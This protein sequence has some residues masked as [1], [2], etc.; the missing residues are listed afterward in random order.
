MKKPVYKLALPNSSETQVWRQILY[1]EVYA[2]MVVDTHGDY[3]S[4]ETIETMAHNFLK[5][6]YQ[7]NI[8]VMHDGNHVTACIVESYI[9]REGDPDFTAGAWVVG[10][11]VEDE[12]LWA[13]VVSGKLNGLSLEALATFEDKT[14]EVSIPDLIEGTTSVDQSH[15]HTFR[16]KYNDKGEF[17]GG[18]T[19]E[20]EGHTHTISHPTFTETVEGHCHKFDSVD[21]FYILS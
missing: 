8:D 13:D 3:M 16:A 6:G 4:A 21:G 1:S 14:V 17:V 9:A 11:H 12:A 18:V 5:D 20:V 2:P 7:R 15:S 10:I 19:D